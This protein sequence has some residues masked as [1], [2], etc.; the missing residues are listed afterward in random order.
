MELFGYKCRKSF[1]EFVHGNG[2]PHVRLNARVIRFERGPLEDWIRTRRTN[3]RRARG[4]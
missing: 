3:P 1:W 4:A 2:V